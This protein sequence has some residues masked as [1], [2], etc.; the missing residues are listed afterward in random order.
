MS[1]NSTTPIDSIEI[2]ELKAILNKLNASLDESGKRMESLTIV[3]F[4]VATFQLI[5]SFLQFVISFTYSDNIEL[6]IF[7]I[8]FSVFILIM[9]IYIKWKPLKE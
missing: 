8:S 5:I 1:I 7:G 3:M 4:L 9:L 2:K 6:K